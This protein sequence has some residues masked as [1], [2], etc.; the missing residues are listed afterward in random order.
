[1][2]RCLRC[3]QE[4]GHRWERTV[5]RIHRHLGYEAARKACTEG[6]VDMPDHLIAGTGGRPPPPP[7]EEDPDLAAVEDLAAN[8]AGLAAL[9]DASEDDAAAI[10]KGLAV[11]GKLSLERTMEAS[12]MGDSMR[13]QRFAAANQKIWQTYEALTGGMRPLPPKIRVLFPIVRSD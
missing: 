1:M 8:V 6:G 9:R 4:L 5:L 11:A 10:A 3:S 12:H 7:L 2:A 13:T